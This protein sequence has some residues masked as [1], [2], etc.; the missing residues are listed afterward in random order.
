MAGET[1]E[2][3]NESK[4]Y[5]LAELK[6]VFALGI[7]A[8][9]L[10]LVQFWTAERNVSFLGL[11]YP[12]TYWGIALIGWQSYIF[13]AIIATFASYVLAMIF[14][15]SLGHWKGTSKFLWRVG[16]CLFFVGGVLMV[17]EVG[18]TVARAIL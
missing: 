17:V 16:D 2:E 9:M 5:R 18:V 7:M 4:R 11:T 3:R 6:A 8:G 13:V 1:P 12:S 14:S 15:L 10:A